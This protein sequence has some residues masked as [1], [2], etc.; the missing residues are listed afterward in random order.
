MEPLDPVT[1]AH[2]AKL[3]D[4]EVDQIIGRLL[5]VGV[6]LAALVVLVGG[7]MFLREHGATVADFRAFVPGTSEL[8]SL[9][10]IIH[11]ALAGDSAAITQ[12]GLVL[13]IATPVARVAL[14]L[15][16]F[17]Y[18]RDRLYVAVT[19]L[20]LALLVYGLVWGKA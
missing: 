18:Q 5:Q 2:R 6:L 7:A 14:T 11:G 4:H 9:S 13:L 3:T 8:R 20:V 15:V 19:T 1:A 16:A 12:L 10:G 17:L